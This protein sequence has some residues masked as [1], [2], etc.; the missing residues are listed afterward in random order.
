VQ[1]ALPVNKHNPPITKALF[2]LNELFLCG[3][4]I[5]LG[6]S[7]EPPASILG[8]FRKVDKAAIHSKT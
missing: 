2:G 7:V 4:V 6:V 1:M 3:P 5:G 8:N